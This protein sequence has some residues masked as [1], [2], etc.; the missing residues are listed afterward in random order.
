MLPQENS[1]KAYTCR[2]HTQPTF[3]FRSWTPIVCRNLESWRS[4]RSHDALC[5]CY[6][7]CRFFERPGAS[8]V[9]QKCF[10]LWRRVSMPQMKSCVRRPN[11]SRGK[12]KGQVYAQEYPASVLHR[13]RRSSRSYQKELA[14]CCRVCG[15]GKGWLA[16]HAGQVRLRVEGAAECSR[17]L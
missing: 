16:V 5:F 11:Y 9:H 8:L 4:V 12:S 10:A 2:F 6:T 17:Q 13:Y 1:K 15:S 7:P 14:V 3:L